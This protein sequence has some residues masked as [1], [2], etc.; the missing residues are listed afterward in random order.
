MPVTGLKVT[1]QCE[2]HCRNEEVLLGGVND[3]EDGDA[4]N[5]DGDWCDYVCETGGVHS[6]GDY[7]L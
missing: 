4:S 1:T 5:R 2:D 7:R 6:A 3:K